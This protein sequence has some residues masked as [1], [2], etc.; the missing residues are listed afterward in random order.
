MSDNTAHRRHICNY[1]LT[2]VSYIIYMFTI[3]SYQISH[4]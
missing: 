4:G 3:Y 1:G 2:N